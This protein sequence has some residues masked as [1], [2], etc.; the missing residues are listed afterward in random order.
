M[1]FG[2]QAVDVMRRRV[3]EPGMRLETR[4]LSCSEHGRLLL[5]VQ[6]VFLF[7]VLMSEIKLWLFDFH[8][9]ECSRC[10]NGRQKQ[11]TSQLFSPV[12]SFFVRINDHCHMLV[13]NSYVFLL[14]FV[15]PLMYAMGVGQ[16]RGTVIKQA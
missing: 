9:F 15:N 14:S 4:T 6:P 12:C 2:R 8:L 1:H 5:V 16:A 7:K 10:G 11:N 3:R 13:I